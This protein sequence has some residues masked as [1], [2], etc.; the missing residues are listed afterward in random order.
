MTVFR[1]SITFACVAA[2]TALMPVHIS[3]QGAPAPPPGDVT[4]TGSL[5]TRVES[6]DWFG[7]SPE[8]EY[9][10]SGSLLRVRAAQTRKRIDWQA[11]LAVPVL[12]GLPNDAVAPG[13]QGALGL[14]ANYFA[15]NDNETNVAGLFV[16]Q[17]AL[18]FKR[19]GGVD[20]QS[21][22]IGRFEFVDG[23]ETAPKDPTLAALKR[24]RIAHRLIGTFAFSHVGRSFDGA[25]YGLD[26]G[27][28][29][30]TALAVR[31]TRGVFDVDGWNE[32]DVNVFYGA[33]TRRIGPA[34][35]AG[36]WRVFGIGYGDYRHDVLKV[37]NRPLATRRA[38]AE[39]IDIA[40]FGG[41][42]LQTRKSTSGTVDLL[43]WAAAQAGSWGTL[44]H[45]AVAFAAEGGWQPAVTLAPWF[46]G[47][48]N[49]GT[50]DG[51]LADR[52]H[53]T[54]FQVLPTPRVY[55]RLPF[56]N[57]MNTSDA[58]GEVAL[59][60]WR[61]IGVRGSVHAIRLASPDDLWY[62]GGGAFQPSTFGYAGRTSNLHTPLST[63]TDASAD[64][65]L[66][67]RVTLSGYL[68]YAAGRAVTDAIYGI[69][70]ARFGYVE[71]IVRF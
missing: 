52:R 30:V 29:N 23:T 39:R 40:T 54:F 15:A 42:Y 43:L 45:R 53:G 59:S 20:G 8:G 32:L 44:S 51:E 12:L 17:L 70:G 66:S 25:Q 1:R 57:M 62:Q 18:R 21:L 14:G 24:D 61:K 65:T 69:G 3:A 5:R 31:P 60:P 28:W 6:W 34:S 35:H 33:L 9:T 49:Y 11:E 7:E 38:D 46:R 68:A 67:S 48:W 26:R 13:A 50:G 41:H 37:D 47:G 56:Y 71:L 63:L 27:D 16:K 36:E 4:V 10:Y 58:F 64:V 2:L 22:K 55:A 19:V